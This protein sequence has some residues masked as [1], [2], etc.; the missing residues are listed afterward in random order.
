LS[1]FQRLL[2]PVSSAAFFEEYFETKPLVVARNRPDYYHR[3]LSLE[4]VDKII[5]TEDVCYPDIRLVS[6][7]RE[8]KSDAYTHLGDRVDPVRLYQLY[9]DG[10]TIILDHLHRSHPPLADLCASLELEFSAP[11]QTNVYLTPPGAKGFKAHFD[12]HDVFVLQLHGK[13]HWR[14][15]GTPVPLPVGEQGG[16]PC[17]SNPGIP[18]LESCLRPGDTLYVP[19]GVVHDAISEDEPSLH[20]T[21][22]LLSYTW[23]DLMLEALAIVALKDSAFR[24]S[25][26]P[27]FAR[28]G[29][30]RKSLTLVFDELLSRFSASAD[31][32]SAMD[33]FATEFI[34]TRWPRLRGQMAQLGASENLTLDSQVA[35]RPDLAYALQE[36]GSVISI[37][38]WG[39]SIRLPKGAGVSLRYALTVPCFQVRDLPGELD[40][41]SKL[42]LVRRLIREGILTTGISPK[43][44]L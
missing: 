4:D 40:D 23:T 36:N 35:C 13:K 2:A 24:R 1:L 44:V 28:P 33:T 7:E 43:P 11:F 19:R 15:Y 29:F 32:N 39:N 22:G 8:I 16:D 18:T 10:A 12:N 5:A 30:D 31:L 41:D 9:A 37:E 17:Q 21:V 25:L 26:P 14:L 20:A 38:Y 27:G 42:V 3:L 34:R 6:A